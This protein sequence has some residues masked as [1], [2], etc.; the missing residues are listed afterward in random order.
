[1]PTMVRSLMDMSADKCKV[2]AKGIGFTATAGADTN[3]DYKFTEARL[4]DGTQLIIKDHAFG[5]SVS[6]SVV[7]VDNVLG[8]G[9][10]LVL[11]MFG[12]RWYVA[13]DKQDQGHIRFPYS[14]EVIQGLY[15]RTTYHS[16]GASDVSIKCNIFAHKYMA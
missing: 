16:V 15:L 12:D 13:S 14:A 5:D 7:D 11:D 9:A 10:G 3:Y 1:M 2:R 6:F 8:Y 4:I